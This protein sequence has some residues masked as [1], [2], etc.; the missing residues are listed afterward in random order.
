M[1]YERALCSTNEERAAGMLSD[2]RKVARL[3]RQLLY[4][5]LSGA[6]MDREEAMERADIL[7]AGEGLR[8]RIRHFT[9]G[10]AIGQRG[11]SGGALFGDAGLLRTEP[12]ERSAQNAGTPH[13]IKGAPGRAT[14]QH[15]AICKGNQ[16]TE[17]FVNRASLPGSG[18]EGVS[19][20]AS[21]SGQ[22][23]VG[24]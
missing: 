8:H 23:A 3:Y 2:W 1:M 17:R 22:V 11:I 20:A 9:E 21:G 10:L 4:A 14:L 12:K 24:T 13:P 18:V 19:L 15:C 5:D 6:E 16:N 7:P